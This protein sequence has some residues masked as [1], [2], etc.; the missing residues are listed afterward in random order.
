MGNSV[1]LA[2]STT[3]N[4]ADTHNYIKFPIK[5]RGPKIPKISLSS[6]SD[7]TPHRHA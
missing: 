7:M 1:G 6:N 4:L 3:E 5:Y 2:V